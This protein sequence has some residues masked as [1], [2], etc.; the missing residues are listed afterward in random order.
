M[1]TVEWLHSQATLVGVNRRTLEDVTRD[2]AE[3][4][5]RAKGKNAGLDMSMARLMLAA[6]RL[7][8]PARAY[9]EEYLK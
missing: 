1:R 5:A 6:G 8:D 2:L 7:T 9:V 3:C 4:K